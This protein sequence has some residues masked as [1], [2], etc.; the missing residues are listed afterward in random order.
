MYF[1]W[2]LRLNR[3]SFRSVHRLIHIHW[4]TFTGELASD[5]PPAEVAGGGRERHFTGNLISD[6]MEVRRVSLPPSLLKRSHSTTKWKLNQAIPG[7]IFVS[8][9]S[10]HAG[11][12][13]EEQCCAHPTDT[14]NFNTTGLFV[15]FLLETQ[16]PKLAP[17]S[18]YVLATEPELAMC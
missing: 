4:D 10:D 12:F 16:K 2:R 3:E 18:C 9:P 17:V 11:N 13:I 8:W 6:Q 14:D 7:L 15:A 5:W 1:Q